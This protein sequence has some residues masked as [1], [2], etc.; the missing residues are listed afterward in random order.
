MLLME[1]LVAEM[2][3]PS[4]QK[5][6]SQVDLT[7]AYALQQMWSRAEEIA[8]SIA[9]YRSALAR[10]A[11]VEA[12]IE[13]GQFAEASKDLLAMPSLPMDGESQQRWEII[14]RQL[15]LAEVV[16]IYPEMIAA[17]EK[18]NIRVPPQ[19]KGN[20]KTLPANQ[21][22]TAAQVDRKLA[23]AKM[24]SDVKVKKKSNS[25]D[26][27]S[28]SG[29][30]DLEA[31]ES[32]EILLARIKVKM[33]LQVLMARAEGLIALERNEDA[34]HLLLPILTPQEDNSFPNLHLQG[35]YYILCWKAGLQDQ[36]RPLLP[37][38]F[39]SLRAF[40][41]QHS[42]LGDYLAVGI[43]LATL[44]GKP[45]AALRMLEY[46]REGLRHHSEFSRNKNF[47]R[48]GK[49]CWESKLGKEARECWE[50]SLQGASVIP[51][52]Q[53][54]AVGAFEV[55][56]AQQRVSSPT[57]PEEEK[58]IRDILQKLPE[59]YSAIGVE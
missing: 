12:R 2:R 8:R 24:D 7:K 47:A 13:L 38:L 32:G 1:K 26:L 41:I 31:P 37:P 46:G 3:D 57:L 45:E 44:D 52:P 54:R 28:K 9:N 34:R 50:R 11:L 21:S 14:S 19:F 20:G 4:S 23:S 59:A 53:S 49:G 16:N 42:D 43:V 39:E 10:L 15:S 36:V 5:S 33:A 22:T 40:P 17:Y 55:L 18:A 29:A 30:V 56:L 51:N 35:E 6:I 48:L 27:S 58:Q 25:E